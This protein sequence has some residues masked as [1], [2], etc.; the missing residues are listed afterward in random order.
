MKNVVSIVQVHRLLHRSRVNAGQTPQRLCEVAVRPRIILRPTGE[1]LFPVRAAIAVT[2]YKAGGARR[3]IHQSGEDPFGLFRGV[4][5]Q[6][7]IRVFHARVFPER[8][9]DGKQR[10]E[11]SHPARSATSAICSA[12]WIPPTNTASTSPARRWPRA[13]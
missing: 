7:E 11:K 5:R 4:R 12:S 3:R 2:S 1:A 8:A 9:L 6:R 13:R 10:A